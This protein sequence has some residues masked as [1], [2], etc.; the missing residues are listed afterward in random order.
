MQKPLEDWHGS[1]NSLKAFALRHW[2]VE[3]ML[4]ELSEQFSKFVFI[5]IL[6]STYA[7]SGRMHAIKKRT[8]KGYVVKHLPSLDIVRTVYFHPS[9]LYFFCNVPLIVFSYPKILTSLIWTPFC[10]L[11]FLQILVFF[12]LHNLS[13]VLVSECFFFSV[14]SLNQ[15]GAAHCVHLVG[16]FLTYLVMSIIPNI[17]H[18]TLT[19][20]TTVQLEYTYVNFDPD[21]LKFFVGTLL[22]A[23]Y[24]HILEPN[25]F[26]ETQGSEEN[27]AVMKLAVRCHVGNLC[28]WLPS[29]VCDNDVT[30]QKVQ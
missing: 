10:S 15:L 16:S 19:G 25:C 24:E 12:S 7:I 29:L 18:T 27:W 2:L 28:W 4:T 14:K 13:W 5:L 23:M 6:A 8:R 30:G 11:F 20:P 3:S 26:E 1:L 17:D 21:T 9:S 22:Y